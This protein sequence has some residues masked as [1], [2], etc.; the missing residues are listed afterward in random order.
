MNDNNIPPQ[1]FFISP[2]GHVI[3]VPQLHINAICAAPGL[4]GFSDEYLRT[5]FLTYNEG[6]ETEGRAREEII[7][8]L[9]TQNWVRVRLRNEQ[10]K[11]PV[12]VFQVHTLNDVTVLH[13]IDFARTVISG[14]GILGT[15]ASPLTTASVK[16]ST[17]RECTDGWLTLKDLPAALERFTVGTTSLL[18]FQ[19]ER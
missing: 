13:I 10:G 19:S 15:K 3:P 2:E 17:G 14:D 8:H 18:S 4:F 6:W 16:I 12:C 1:A 5:K 9:L 7:L 11:G